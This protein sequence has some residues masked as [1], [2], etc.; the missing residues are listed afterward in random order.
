MT[1]IGCMEID[2]KPLRTAREQFLAIPGLIDWTGWHIFC[3]A[4]I[5]AWLEPT[6][7]KVSLAENNKTIIHHHYRLLLVEGADT[8]LTVLQCQPP[9]ALQLILHGFGAIHRIAL[10]KSDI[11]GNCTIA[12]WLVM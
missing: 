11:S 12:S 8:L 6:H 1:N 9:S 4:S 7:P 5:Y 2:R 3:S 10:R